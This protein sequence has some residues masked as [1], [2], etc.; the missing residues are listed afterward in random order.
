MLTAYARCSHDAH[1]VRPLFACCSLQGRERARSGHLAVVTA[2]A[3]G[4]LRAASCRLGGRRD[5][6]R[7]VERPVSVREEHAVERLEAGLVER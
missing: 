3:V 4:K 1:C 2:G 6:E 5:G 7:S